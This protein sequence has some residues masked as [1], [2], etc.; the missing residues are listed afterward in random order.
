MR[1]RITRR[2]RAA[3]LR[4]TRRTARR[5][6][7]AQLRGMTRRTPRCVRSAQLCGMSRR[8]ACLQLPLHRFALRITSPAGDA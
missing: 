2:V 6:G 5:V 4:M 7:P 1:L 3:K 8:A